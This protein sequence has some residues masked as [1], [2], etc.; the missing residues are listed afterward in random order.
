MWIRALPGSPAKLLLGEHATPEAVAQIRHQYGLDEPVYVQYWAYL[1]TLASGDLGTSIA[2]TR[3]VTYAVKHRFPA[4]IELALAAMIFAIG[5]GVPLGFPSA[6]RY[7]SGV[8]HA[9]LA[10]SLIGIIPIFFLAIILKYIFS[11]RLG[12]LPRSV[13]RTR[14]ARRSTP[15]TSTS[16]TGSSR[17]TSGRPGTRSST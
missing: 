5:V 4:T 7:R 6:K 8:D 2:S 3:T 1:K 10:A 11:V 14:S 15:R 17:A 16:S 9:G 12:W 13:E